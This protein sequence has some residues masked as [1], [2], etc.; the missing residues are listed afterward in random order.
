MKKEYK[1]YTISITTKQRNGLWTAE[2]WIWPV[3]GSRGTLLDDW[4][5]EGWASQ[6]EAE[7][8]GRGFGETRIDNWLKTGHS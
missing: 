8:A 2:I 3:I 6:G 4:Q 7:E 1:G 5:T